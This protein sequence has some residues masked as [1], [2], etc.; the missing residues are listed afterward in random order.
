MANIKF[1]IGDVVVLKSGKG[2]GDFTGG[3]NQNMEQHVGEIRKIRGIDPVWSGGRVSYTFDGIEF[4]WDE[5]CLEKVE[6]KIVIK[7]DGNKVIATFGNNKGVAKCSPEDDFDMYTGAKIALDRVFNEE[8]HV[9]DVVIGNES[10][11]KYGITRE[12]Y[13]G[14]VREVDDR[15]IYIVGKDSRHF[16]VDK[17]AFDMYVPRADWDD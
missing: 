10:A 9:G 16:E 14:V 3:W 7:R 4:F 2:M 15:E 5:R 6:D 11:N 12:G 8:F 13:V 1:K 17:T